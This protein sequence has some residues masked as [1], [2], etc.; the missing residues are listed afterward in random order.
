MLACQNPKTGRQFP[1]L[2]RGIGL[3]CFDS[4]S[5][6]LSKPLLCNLTITG[7]MA[8]IIVVETAKPDVHIGFWD[9]FR[10]GFPI[11]FLTILFGL[12]WIALV[13]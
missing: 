11:T 8:N 1:R 2:S 6:E 7:S 9:Y 10:M 5:C 4:C 3:R 12:A 13:R